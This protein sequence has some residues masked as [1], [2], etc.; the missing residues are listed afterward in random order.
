PP[1]DP[2]SRRP[3]PMRA[4]VL[5][6]LCCSLRLLLLG[7]F[8]CCGH[9]FRVAAEPVGLSDELAVVR[10][11]NLYPAAA[12]MVGRSDL[13]WWKQAAQ[14]QIV[15]LLE[16]ILYIR[17]GRLLPAISL[18]GVADRLDMDRRIEDAAV[19]DHRIVHRL[20]RFLT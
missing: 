11:E 7:F 18:D 4:P 6:P 19:V 20:W 13:Q 5:L 17:A 8:D 10:L 12:F 14:R 1:P 2:P 15:D 16:T 9:N 3:R